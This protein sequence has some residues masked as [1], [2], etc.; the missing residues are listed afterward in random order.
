MNNHTFFISHLNQA[1][2][3]DR[4]GVSQRTL[5]R[6]RAIGWGPCFLK[7][8]GRVVYRLEDIEAYELKHLR[9]STS[10][11]AALPY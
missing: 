3:S 1:Q 2:L 9:T 8:G 11:P 10:T 6:W 7:M 4:W 5:E